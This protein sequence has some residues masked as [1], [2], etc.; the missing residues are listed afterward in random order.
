DLN[1]G[2]AA[3]ALGRG[4]EARALFVRSVWIQPRL[5]DTLPA[6]EREAVAAGVASAE[7][8]LTHGGPV[9]PAPP[10]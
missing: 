9:P 1:L 7:E 2:R 6:G 8:G 4:Q 3:A 10:N 5:L